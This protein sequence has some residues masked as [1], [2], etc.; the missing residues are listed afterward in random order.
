[1]IPA[2]AYDAMCRQAEA[3]YPFE[4]CGLLFGS[5]AHLDVVPMKNLQNE[6]HARD[7]A[8]FPRDAR[9]AYY[10]DP[11]E[12]ARVLAEKEKLQEPMRAIYHSHPDHDAYFSEKD[13]S[14]AAPPGLGPLFPDC[15]Y[16]VLSVRRGRTAEVKGYLWSEAAQAFIEAAIVRGVQPAKLRSG[17]VEA[18]APSRPPDRGR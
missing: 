8:N 14:D 6:M 1:M 10:F 4:T 18:P 11:R 9:T 5:G 15:V 2:M 12:F 17:A 16:I 13:A 3:D 7:P